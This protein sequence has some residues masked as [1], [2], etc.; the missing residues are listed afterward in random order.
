MPLEICNGTFIRFINI[1]PSGSQT[2]A[3]WLTK[4]GIFNSWEDISSWEELGRKSCGC[5][6]YLFIHHIRQP[7]AL[8]TAS[9]S[10]KILSR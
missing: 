4:G 9:L 8:A 10:R 2:G 3:T 7:S 6:Y 1:Y 5:F